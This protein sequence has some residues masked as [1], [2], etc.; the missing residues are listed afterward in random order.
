MRFVA[1]LALACTPKVATVE[2]AVAPGP[3]PITVVKSPIDARSYAVVTLDNGI[4][5]LLISDPDTDMAAASL[6]VHVGH[7]ADPSDRQGLAHFLEHMLFMGTDRFPEPDE[8][9]KF[10]E[11]HGGNTNAG[12]SGESTEYHF[13]VEQGALGP[14]FERFSR[15]FVAPLLDPAYVE[16]ERNAV[17]AEYTLKLQDDARRARQVRKVTTNPAH[18]E[19]KFSVGNLETLADR[20]GD[21][22]YEDLRALYEA[23]YRPDRM[24]VAILGREPVETLREWVVAGLGEVKGTPAAT[25]SRLPPFLPEQLGVRIDVVSLDERRELELQFPVPPEHAVWPSWPYNY[26]TSLLGHEGEGTL[27]TR[28][29]EAGWI[30]SLSAGTADGADD[31]DLLSID[32]SLTEAG[33]EHVD[34]IVAACFHTIRTIEASG[35]EAFRYDEARTVAELAFRFGEEDQPVSAVQSAVYALHDYPP[36]HVL[37]WWSVY[38]ELEPDRIRTALAAM[39][40]EN[41]RLIVTGPALATDRTEPLYDVPYAVRPTTEA[42]RSAFSAG[43]PLEVALPEPNPYLPERTALVPG[44]EAPAV[45]VKI[46]ADGDPIELWHL[47]DTEFGVP[48]AYGMLRV[49]SPASRRDLRTLVLAQLYQSVQDDALQAFRYPLGQA[50]L[51]FGTSV[52]DRGLT[53]LFWGFDDGQERM[54]RDLCTRLAGFRVDPARFELERDEL[55]RRWKNLKRERPISQAWGAAGEVIDPWDFDAVAGIAVAEKLTAADLQAFVAEFWKGAAGGQLLVHGNQTADAAR[56]MAATI[57]ETLP[58]GKPGV[59]P[60]AAVRRFPTK[61]DAVR[62][63]RIDHTDST[64]VVLYQG[65]GTDAA[66]RA[67]WV[68]LGQLLDTP[69]FTE[70][71]TEQQL[72]YVVSAGFRRYDVLPGLQ[73]SIQSAVHGPATLLERV[74]AFLATETTDLA[75]MSDEDFLTIRSGLVARLREADTRLYQRSERFVSNLRDGVPTFDWREQ[76]AAEVEKLDRATMAAFAAEVL[77][78]GTGRLVVRS[79]GRG[80]GAEAGPAGC[81]DTACVVKKLPKEPF[82]RPL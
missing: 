19:S 54:L 8:Y 43:T 5:A 41:L 29:K 66:A 32:I 65:E 26:V 39:K 63:V 4:R 58:V 75:A 14:T 15:F 20:E 27:F 30:E 67:R 44:G 61:G 57:A 28:L 46:S 25:A 70:L 72:G 35:I 24:T 34:D 79:V 59:R 69:F 13:E 17:N 82:R 22:V 45:P 53:L 76:V 56:A 73:L 60:E 21:P 62:E 55:V 3:A 50:G 71:R 81:A 12:T 68:L 6:A 42:E 36:E 47:Q 52:D 78:P 38:G 31:Y 37:D 80:H 10:V 23:E 9:R 16:R 77:A 1:L 51:G 2:P 11:D 7:Y 18:P 64:L 74:D 49:W 40:P 33:A 48:R